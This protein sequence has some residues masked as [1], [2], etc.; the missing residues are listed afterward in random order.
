LPPRM[1]ICRTEE[2]RDIRQTHYV[3]HDLHGIAAAQFFP[4]LPA[5]R[6]LEDSPIIKDQRE[7]LVIEMVPCVNELEVAEKRIGHINSNLKFVDP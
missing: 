5:A 2:F 4:P 1:R 6:V 7:C 3:E